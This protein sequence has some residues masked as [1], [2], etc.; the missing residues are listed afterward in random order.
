MTTILIITPTS[1]QHRYRPESY[2]A[3]F[4]PIMHG[5]TIAN[6]NNT[7]SISSTIASI[8]T[9]AV[10]N[11]SNEWLSSGDSNGSDS[12]SESTFRGKLYWDKRAKVEYSVDLD[13]DYWQHST[14]LGHINGI[15][16]VN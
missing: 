3:S 12:G 15:V 7:A 10:D 8:S 5:E 11:G 4:L 2:S 9:S 14:F 1:F 13:V 16:Y 6:K